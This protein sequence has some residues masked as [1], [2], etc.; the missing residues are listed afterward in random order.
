MATD[1]LSDF[2]AIS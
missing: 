1:D 2:D